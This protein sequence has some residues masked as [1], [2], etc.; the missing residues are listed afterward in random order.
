MLL[1][2]LIG[3]DDKVVCAIFYALLMLGLILPIPIVDG[4][5]GFV[6]KA[7]TLTM[8]GKATII[9]AGICLTIVFLSLIG[10]IVL[11]II[12]T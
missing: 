2:D 6:T 8:L 3:I 10:W 7:S 1:S 12:Y 4:K 9:A 5:E 11:A